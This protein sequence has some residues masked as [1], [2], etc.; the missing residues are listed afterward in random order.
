AII[1]GTK[2]FGKGSVQTIITLPGHGAMRLTTAR[3]YTPSG[4]SIQAK[5][6]DPDIIVEQARIETV[7]NGYEK[8]H[9]ADLRGALENTGESYESNKENENKDDQNNKT[10]ANTNQR[11]TDDYQLARAIDLLKGIH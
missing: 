1:M 6:I 5:G 10:D 9:E 7:D 11:N 2:T 4:R 8:I 3:Y